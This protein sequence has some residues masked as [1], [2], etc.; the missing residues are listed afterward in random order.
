MQ[1][2]EYEYPID[3][4][5][6]ISTAPKKSKF[7]GDDKT[8]F[9]VI[10]LALIIAIAAGLIFF[11][12]SR[13]SSADYVVRLNARTR[14]LQ[15][16]TESSHGKITSSDLR[17]TNANLNLA[18]V[19]MRRGVSQQIA[20]HK[21]VMAEVDPTL[22]TRERLSDLSEKLEEARINA[23][24]DR[25]YAREMSYELA[26]MIALLKQTRSH[27]NNQS[28]I[29]FTIEAEQ[30]MLPLQEQFLS[31]SDTATN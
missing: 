17:G 27:S 13:S 10:I 8:F 9:I 31:S 2:K 7:S 6:E 25:I 22:A 28:L 12:S 15:S 24:F 29:N 30:K 14:N 18:L 1:P 26:S 23:T 16:I 4:L 21:I 19:E 3:Y 5:E 11:L 20:N